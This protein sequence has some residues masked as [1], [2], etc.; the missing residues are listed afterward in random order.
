MLYERLKTFRAVYD[1]MS[2]NK[3]AELLHLTQS[4][5]SQQMSV[6]E[7]LYRV[8]LF[9]RKGRSI[10]FT[11]EGKALYEWTGGIVSSMEEIPKRLRA[12]KNL[13]Y[14]DGKLVVGTTENAGMVLS[15]HLE[16]FSRVFPGIRIKVG[17][18]SEIALKQELLAN[19][20]D[21]IAVDEIFEGT[22][23]TGFP[24]RTLMGGLSGFSLILPTWHLW[25]RRSSVSPQ[26]LSDEVFLMHAQAPSLR[27]YVEQYFLLN[28]VAPRDIIEAGS[29]D[30]IKSMVAN[31]M[32]VSIVGD[33]TL[34]NRCRP[35]GIKVLALSG[36]E[37]LKRHVW[38][39]YPPNKEIG[40]TAWAF[41]RLMEPDGT[42]V[43]VEI[44]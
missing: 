25:A 24:A 1:N 12:L 29:T 3:A 32:G 42:D 4:A 5:V 7:E 15:R 33:I 17:I 19:E 22:R 18:G 43:A 23:D 6:L 26:D 21:F 14:G 31:G 44:G 34:S 9:V 2:V 28:G 16:K 11:P 36:L 38:L 40:Y 30:M 10:Q 39:L 35:A 20:F 37:E 8:K 41:L 13:Q 27:S